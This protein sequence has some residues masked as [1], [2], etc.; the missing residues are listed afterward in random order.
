MNEK[1]HYQIFVQGNF[2]MR[3]YEKVVDVVCTREELD[4][5]AHA[6]CAYV[7]S[8]G[9]GVCCVAKEGD[10]VDKSNFDIMFSDCM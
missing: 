3:D 1:K 7:R 5:I 6:M 8:T 10:G 2:E 9:C 4:M